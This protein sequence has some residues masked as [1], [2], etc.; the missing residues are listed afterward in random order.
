M[1]RAYCSPS[2]GGKNVT[3]TLVR[4]LRLCTGRTAHRESTSIA[5]LFLDHGSRRGLR[6]KRHA[7][8]ALY[9]G[10]DPVPILQEAGWARGS[11]CTGAENLAHTG[12]DPRTVQPVAS[13][14]TDWATRPTIIRRYTVCVCVY[15][16]MCVYVCVC[17][18]IYIYVCVCMYVCMCMYIYIYTH[19]H[20]HTHTAIGTCCAF[21][22]LS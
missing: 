7:L 2:S 6:D 16:Y 17:V 10:K 3:C 15:I 4:A 21:S 22:W 14:Y 11:V 9:P 20:T 13:R 19:T 18:Y 5:L 12:F 1:F 8:A